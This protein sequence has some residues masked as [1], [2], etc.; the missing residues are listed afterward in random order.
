MLKNINLKDTSD[1]ISESTLYDSCRIYDYTDAANPHISPI[2]IKT[3]DSD[4]LSDQTQIEHLDISSDL[5]YKYLATSPNLLAQFIK[6]KSNELIQTDLNA[7]SQVYYIIEGNGKTSFIVESSSKSLSYNIE[8]SK[9]D[10]F[11][12]P[13]TTYLIHKAYTDTIIYSINDQPLLEYLAVKPSYPKFKPTVFK[14]NITKEALNEIYKKNILRNLNRLGILLGNEITELTTKTLTHTMW[15]LFNILPANTKQRPHKHNSVALDLCIESSDHD[16][17]YT[18][19]GK[20]L[21]SEGWIINPIK[22]SWKKGSVFITPPG[23]WHSHH[24]ETN[25]DAIV[26]PIQDA[27]LYTYQQT[28]DIRFS[29]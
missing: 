26:L 24:N 13:I 19:I 6:I 12:L 22:C 1:E 18:L 14:S 11:V 9:G 28:L 7:T 3:F 20:E 21:D 10:L 25:I 23:M 8:W 17:I 2:P 5:G 27:G 4:T 29:T 16:K 15:S